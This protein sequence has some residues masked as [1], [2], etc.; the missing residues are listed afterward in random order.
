MVKSCSRCHA[1]FGHQDQKDD[2]QI[3]FNVPSRSAP[4]SAETTTAGKDLS[5]QSDRGERVGDTCGGHRAHCRL[6][7]RWRGLAMRGT[8]HTKPFLLTNS[9]ET[10]MDI[11]TCIDLSYSSNIPTLD[12]QCLKVLDTF[13]NLPKTEW[14][15]WVKL[16]STAMKL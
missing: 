13:V 6:G 14:L 12:G 11:S 4:L 16:I 10:R 1:I 8:A 3:P 9:Y 7:R 15:T 5:P 2:D